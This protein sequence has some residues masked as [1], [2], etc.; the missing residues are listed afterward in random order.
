M[1]TFE[2][3]RGMRIGTAFL[4][5]MLR[6]G[7]PMGP[8]CL[9]T[10]QGRKSGKFYST[11][12]ALVERDGTRWLVAAFGETNW[13]E[14]IRASGEA[15]LG[16]GRRS[17]TIQVVE[18][19]TTDSAPILQQFLKQFG[20]VPFIPPYFEATSKSPLA[21]FEREAQHHPVFRIVNRQR[22]P[23][24]LAKNYVRCCR[25]SGSPPR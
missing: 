19:D 23:H 25:K 3:T 21:E 4:L 24:I 12:V 17:E 10:H 13:V 20:L 7:V 5:R 22:I 6:L 1:K 2:M 9:L 18:L 8:L 16:S 15:Q 14:N 11:P